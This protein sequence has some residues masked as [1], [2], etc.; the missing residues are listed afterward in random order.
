[1]DTKRTHEWKTKSRKGEA[2]RGSTGADLVWDE[3]FQLSYDS[4]ELAFLR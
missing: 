1:M 4:D 2:A 3:K